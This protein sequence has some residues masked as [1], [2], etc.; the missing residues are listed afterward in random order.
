MI[1]SGTS[2]DTLRRS[3]LK[4]SGWAVSVQGVNA[5]V[6]LAE[7]VILARFLPLESFGVLIV[8]TSAVDFVFGLLD[9]RTGQAVIKF[10]PEFGVHDRR[11]VAAFLKMML[12]IDLCIGSVGLAGIALFGSAIARVA[13][14]SDGFTRLM[15]VLAIGGAL[16]SLV[17]SAGSYLRVNGSFAAAST[18]SILVALLR[19]G[20]VLAIAFSNPS[21]ERFATGIAVADALFFGVMAFASFAQAR[22]NHEN[23]LTASLRDIATDRRRVRAFL[24]STNIESTIKTISGKVDVLLLALI[25]TPAAVAIYKVATR[26]A[27]TLL[28]FSDP[29]LMA[30]YPEL[31]R[32]QAEGRSDTAKRFLLQMTRRLWPVALIGMTLFA[33]LGRP[34][35]EWLAGPDYAAA[36]PAALVMTLGTSLA[37]IFFWARPLLLVQGRSR[38]LVGVIALAA[39]TQFALFA[40]LAPS[41]GALGGAIGYA[42]FF[43]TSAASCL[44]LLR[45]DLRATGVIGRVLEN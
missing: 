15:I 19:I 35:L 45:D 34:L 22:R 7:T 13:D 20:I 41:I 25:A 36:H 11:Q 42:A 14:L 5:V 1:P 27:G 38:S 24:L 30:I 4:N 44:W 40:L 3:I 21:L 16:K 6:S 28:L 12:L 31:S 37:M 9:V 43:G 39:F 2:V 29:L 10:A 23:P 33:F 26:M 8:L 32:A 17:R 18:L